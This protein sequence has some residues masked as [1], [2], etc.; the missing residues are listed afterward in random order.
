M[1]AR[2]RGGRGGGYDLKP[3]MMICL[4]CMVETGRAG[5]RPGHVGEGGGGSRVVGVNG[6]ARCRVGGLVLMGILGNAVGSSR[7]SRDATLRLD[8]IGL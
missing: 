2:A 6:V 7:S 4:M 3:W 1:D 5:S 8:L